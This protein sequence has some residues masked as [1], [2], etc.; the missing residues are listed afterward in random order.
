MSFEQ[1]SAAKKGRYSH[2]KRVE[3]ARATAQFWKEQQP[4]AESKQEPEIQAGSSDIPDTLQKTNPQNR[5][6]ESIDAQRER[7]IG[8]TSENSEVFKT[9]VEGLSASV[10]F[11][12]D[13][14][15]IPSQGEQ[16]QRAESSD[17]MEI[18]RGLAISTITSTGSDAEIDETQSSCIAEN[19]E[20]SPL[21]SIELARFF[22]EG[23]TTD[24]TG[25]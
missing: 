14:E 10:S 3:T 5:P 19:S 16:L 12:T 18:N 2:A 25:Q 9:T 6:E 13:K 7:L 1:F 8:C 24:R 4:D 20:D 21:P 17:T 15:C 22:N 23:L 11:S